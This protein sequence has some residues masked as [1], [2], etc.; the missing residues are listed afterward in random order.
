M[1]SKIK[2]P[3]MVHTQS[4]KNLRRILDCSFAL[5]IAQYKAEDERLSIVNFTANLLIR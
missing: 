1:S 4:S 5:S 3:E 2:L